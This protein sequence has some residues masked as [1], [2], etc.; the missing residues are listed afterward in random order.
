VPHGISCDTVTTRDFVRMHFFLHCVE[1]DRLN[2]IDDLSG[3]LLF[4]NLLSLFSYCRKVLRG[5]PIRCGLPFA[6]T[7][8]ALLLRYL[9]SIL[10]ALLSDAKVFIAQKTTLRS[11][12]SFV[13][14]TRTNWLLKSS[15][16][17]HENCRP[18][19]IAISEA[20]PTGLF[21]ISGMSPC[22][23]GNVLSCHINQHRILGL[24]GT[25]AFSRFSCGD[26]V[27]LFSHKVCTNTVDFFRY[28][29]IST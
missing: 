22:F 25:T 13:M 9:S 8:A 12:V 19:A 29:A 20:K 7:A 3:L 23:A 1:I 10:I 11:S 17:P 2:N 24:E 5:T 4:S 15:S 28:S 27:T 6:N 26:F 21:L 18:W 14:R 16:Q